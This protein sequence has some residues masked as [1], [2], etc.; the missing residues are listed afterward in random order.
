M[1]DP[2]TVRLKARVGPMQQDLIRFHG[3]LMPARI[4][5]YD[6]H[7]SNADMRYLNVLI[8]RSYE[9]ANRTNQRILRLRYVAA[10][11]PWS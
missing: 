8:S 5:G 9:L 6:L 4:G 11:S 10:P 7:Q 3:W 2:W 1:F